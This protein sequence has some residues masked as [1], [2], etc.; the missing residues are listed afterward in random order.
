MS[1]NTLA[2]YS[3]QTNGV[4]YCD[5]ANPNF[6]VR[7]KT[8]SSQ[9]VL[10]GQKV[11]NYITEITAND[12]HLVAVGSMSV[13]DALSVRIRTSGSLQSMPRL[14]Q[15]LLDMAAKVESWETENVLI[16]FKPVTA[17]INTVA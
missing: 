13:T 16:G 7:F 8:T 4:T 11:Y 6:I 2:L 9:K 1:V 5:A 17:P 15:M 14:K 12:N 3:Q 10:D